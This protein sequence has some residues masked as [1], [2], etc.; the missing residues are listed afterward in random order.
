MTCYNEE[1]INSN[2]YCQKW[3]E[4]KPISP[5]FQK[6]KKAKFPIWEYSHK[7]KFPGKFQRVNSQVFY[8]PEETFYRDSNFQRAYI[9][10]VWISSIFYSNRYN[11]LLM[12]YIEELINSSTYCQKE[13]R[14]KNNF[15]KNSTSENG[16]ISNLGIFPQK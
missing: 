5:K 13:W 15:A 14:K 3:W 16:K 6:R 9:K 1:L 10:M 2:T 11:F 12:C 8:T 7:N 4:K